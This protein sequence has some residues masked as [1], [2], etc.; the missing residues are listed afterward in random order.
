MV[1]ARADPTAIS[2]LSFYEKI[3]LYAFCQEECH[4]DKNYI[5]HKCISKKKT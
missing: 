1:K 2:P 3:R 5:V 4:Y